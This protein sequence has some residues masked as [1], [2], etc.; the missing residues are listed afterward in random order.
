MEAPS[1]S[2]I[3][4]RAILLV[5]LVVAVLYAA[6]FAKKRQRLA[7]IHTELQSI[8]SDSSFFKQFYA[9]D[10]RAALVRAVGLVAEADQLQSPPQRTITRCLGIDN[11]GLFASQSRTP[12]PTP[13]QRIIHACLHANYQNFRKLGYL[14]DPQTLQAAR[15]GELPPIPHGPDAGSQAVVAWVIDPKLAPG[16]DKVVANYELRP[17]RSASQPA[18]MVETAAAKELANDL[19]DARVIEESLR[20]KIIDQLTIPPAPPA[21]R[22]K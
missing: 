10:A 3:I 13:R 20:D 15:R 8:T 2:Y 18:S 17:P 16:L 11:K 6:S 7:A 14:P 21:A 19:A 5:G 4:S 1:P 12:D 9:A 22:P